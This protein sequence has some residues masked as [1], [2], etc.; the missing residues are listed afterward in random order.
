MS[1]VEMSREKK[2]TAAST[3]SRSACQLQQFVQV[4]LSQSLSKREHP[5]GTGQF[6]ISHEEADMARIECNPVENVDGNFTMEEAIMGQLRAGNPAEVAV[7]DLEKCYDVTSAETVDEGD[8][9][10][11][12]AIELSA[13][14]DAICTNL[15]RVLRSPVEYNKEGDFVEFRMVTARPK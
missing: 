7:A 12:A 5:D 11:A 2:A 4:P 9:E 6:A 14:C 3:I 13:K 1:D 15:A 8:A 10:I